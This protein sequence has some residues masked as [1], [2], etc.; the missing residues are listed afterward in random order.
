MGSTMY[1]YI[2]N[3]LCDYKYLNTKATVKLKIAFFFSSAI[4]ISFVIV[5]P[6]VIVFLLGNI[7]PRNN[8]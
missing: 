2:S 5:A 3:P 1:F 4:I 7:P 6:V 8:E